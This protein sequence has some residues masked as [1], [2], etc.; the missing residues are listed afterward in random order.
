MNNA[1][2][3]VVNRHSFRKVMQTQQSLYTRYNGILSDSHKLSFTCHVD[4]LL[5]KFISNLD[6]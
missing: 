6:S 1:K 3:R 4:V 5:D 2:N